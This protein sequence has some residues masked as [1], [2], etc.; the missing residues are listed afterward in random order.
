MTTPPPIPQ[1][2]SNRASRIAIALIALL[3]LCGIAAGFV[4]YGTRLFSISGRSMSPTMEPGDRIVVTRFRG[5]YHRGDIVVYTAPALRAP[6]PPEI[7]VQRIVALPGETLR[8]ADGALII[9]GVRTPVYNRAGEI[10]YTVESAGSF[11]R[12]PEDSV[13]VPVGSYFLMGDN[14]AHSFDSRFRGCISAAS[15]FGRASRCNAQGRSNNEKSEALP[16]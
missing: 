7:F 2:K 4:L 16:P 8:V 6:E 3:V 14:S 10:T 12:N 9:N 13:T 1:K 5:E 11:L 15:I